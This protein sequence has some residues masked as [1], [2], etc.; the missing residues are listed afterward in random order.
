M[1][2]W[3]R[4]KRLLSDVDRCNLI[5]IWPGTAVV[6]GYKMGEFNDDDDDDDRKETSRTMISKS[7]EVALGGP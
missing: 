7:K 5:V 4:A 6:K 1:H 2:V 3:S